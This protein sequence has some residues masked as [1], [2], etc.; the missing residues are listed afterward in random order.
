M[1]NLIEYNE[2]KYSTKGLLSKVRVV[3]WPII[4]IITLYFGGSLDTKHQGKKVLTWTSLDTE[5]HSVSKL[6]V[7]RM[8]IL[9]TSDSI[10][11]RKKT[12]ENWVSS[13]R[14]ESRNIMSMSPDGS[15]QEQ[16]HQTD[17]TLILRNVKYSMWTVTKSLLGFCYF[18]WNPFKWWIFKHVGFL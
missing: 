14:I 1:Q 4:S 3:L 8:S 10:L 12:T 13:L 7:T 17:G 15:L 18:S 6:T 11:L 16:I 2:A 5:Y 9:D